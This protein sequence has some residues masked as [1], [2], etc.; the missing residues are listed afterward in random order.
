MFDNRKANGEDPGSRHVD[1]HPAFVAEKEIGELGRLWFDE[2]LLI[3]ILCS[4]K[5]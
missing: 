1:L 4:T 2:Q 5:D 3:V